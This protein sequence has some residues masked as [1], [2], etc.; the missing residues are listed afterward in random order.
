MTQ[1]VGPLLVDRDKKLMI[2][3]G[4]SDSLAL[5]SVLLR[6]NDADQQE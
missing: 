3:F 6:K 2:P 4:F 5:H 1:I